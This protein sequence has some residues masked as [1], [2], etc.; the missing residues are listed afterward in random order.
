MIRAHAHGVLEGLQ[1]LAHAQTGQAPHQIHIDVGAARL[2]RRKDRVQ[3]VLSPVRTAQ[4]T[5]HA[6]VQ[7]L[8]AD[9]QTVDARRQILLHALPAPQGFRV[10]L[11]GYFGLGTERKTAGQ[12]LQ[13]YAHNARRQQTG[14]APAKKDALHCRP[15]QAVAPVGQFQQQGIHIIAQQG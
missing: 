4:Q 2:A 1:P 7:T 9:G 11:Q 12:T 3:A 14:R 8:D 6:L 5:Q 13:H 10:G 15:V